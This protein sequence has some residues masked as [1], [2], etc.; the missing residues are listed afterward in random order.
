MSNDKPPYEVGYSKPPKS[1][2][3]TKGTSGNP[4]GRPKGSKNLATIFQ[5]ESRQLVRLKGPGGSRTITKLEAA[6]MQLGNKAAQGDLRAQREFFSRVQWAEE[7]TS[8]VGNQTTLP[9][10]DR[11]MLQS[12]AR[13]MQEMGKAEPPNPCKLEEKE[14]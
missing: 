14:S 6:A 11:E 4:K 12:L 2:Q 7:T 5:R 9:E 10:A 3:F 8:S 1:G 13:R